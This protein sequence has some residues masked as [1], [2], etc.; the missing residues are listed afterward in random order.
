VMIGDQNIITYDACWIPFGTQCNG[1]WPT[2]VECGG[3][4]QAEI[5]MSSYIVVWY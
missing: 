3:G 4:Y 5:I 2:P 1:Q